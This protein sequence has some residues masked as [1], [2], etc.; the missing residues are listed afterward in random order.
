MC[1]ISFLSFSGLLWRGHKTE[2]AAGR[3][4][5]LG[6]GTAGIPSFRRSLP[7]FG[8]ELARA[9]RAQRPL[10]V[11]VL[12]LGRDLLLEQEL[13][14]AAAGGNGSVA[15]R[16]QLL[17]RTTHLVSLVLGAILRDALR[18]S[19]IVTYGAADDRYVILLTDTNVVQAQQ[20]VQRLSEL[21]YQRT[22]SYLRAGIAEFP[23]DG[24]T[25][26]DLVS[27]A[28]VA[29]DKRPVGEISASSAGVQKQA[30]ASGRLR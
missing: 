25:L 12:S 15:S 7:E 1:L 19:D 9:R 8:R 27:S 2:A 24:L 22:F 17:K 10:A 30:S 5:S 16:M 6:F 29:W 11:V 4:A 28:Q 14:S 21:F 13:R 23:A 3:A 26:E 20:A 18:E